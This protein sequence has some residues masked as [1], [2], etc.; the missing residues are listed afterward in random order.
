MKNPLHHREFTRSVAPL[1]IHVNHASGS[2][3]GTLRDVSMDGVFVLCEHELRDGAAVKVSIP[4]GASSQGPRI[5]ASGRV[6]R[7]DETG[8]AIHFDGMCHESYEN[9]KQLIL[10]NSAEPGKT[11]REIGDHLGLKS[12]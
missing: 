6:V 9:L 12:R 7:V 8:T 11:E 5:E 1:A 3:E 2:V 4:L 10:L